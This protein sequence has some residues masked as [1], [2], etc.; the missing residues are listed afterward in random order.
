MEVEMKK[1]VA[2][3]ALAAFAALAAPALVVAQG[4]PQTITTVDIKTLATGYRSSKVVGS[5]VINE[6]HETIGKIDDLLISR[7]HHLYAVL[8]VGGFLGM[9]SKLVA[10]QYAQLVPSSDNR[11]FVLAGATKESLKS[12]PEYQYAE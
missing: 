7:D 9:G 11:A 1:L 10:V 3:T 2:V 8:S 5:D 6:K 12:L 4:T